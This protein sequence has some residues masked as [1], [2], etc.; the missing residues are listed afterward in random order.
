MR[1]W[2]GAGQLVSHFPLR[3]S[4]QNVQLYLHAWHHP[5]IFALQIQKSSNSAQCWKQKEL[6]KNTL[7]WELVWPLP[8]LLHVQIELSWTELNWADL[9]APN[10][11]TF[12]ASRLD[13]FAAKI[14]RTHHI[15]WLASP[16]MCPYCAKICW[17]SG[18]IGIKTGNSEYEPFY[19]PPA[20]RKTPDKLHQGGLGQRRKM[21][22][23]GCKIPCQ[24]SEKR[25]S[26]WWI[27]ES[28]CNA[29]SFYEMCDNTSVARW[30]PPGRHMK[31]LTAIK[32]LHVQWSF[33]FIPS[34]YYTTECLMATLMR[35]LG[36][37]DTN[38]HWA[39]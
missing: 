30:P 15:N 24:A 34:W 6:A 27:G 17:F 20:R 21:E 16:E 39:C 11:R 31:L 38:W 7:I 12:G 28:S 25:E 23:E 22:R 4:V 32:C 14:M 18:S 1:A 10:L 19:Q 26:T 3:L 36:K 33:G 37:G 29:R 5:K 9:D 2:T 35:S 8:S 13:A